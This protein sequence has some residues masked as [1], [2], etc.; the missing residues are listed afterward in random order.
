MTVTHINV[1]CDCFLKASQT[2]INVRVFVTDSQGQRDVEVIVDHN[3]QIVKIGKILY[4]SLE[5]LDFFSFPCHPHTTLTR[6]V[7]RSLVLGV[8]SDQVHDRYQSCQ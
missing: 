5:S 4:M 6:R 1:S 2:R 8:G 3:C 7:F